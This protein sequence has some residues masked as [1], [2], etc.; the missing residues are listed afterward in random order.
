M[1]TKNISP[2][3]A[4][5]VQAICLANSLYNQGYR[6]VGFLQNIGMASWLFVEKM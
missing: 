4:E 5:S 2:I 6:V 1:N 3:N